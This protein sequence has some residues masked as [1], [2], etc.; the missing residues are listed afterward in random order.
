M[1]P[2]REVASTCACLKMRKAARAVTRD[3]DRALK[4]AGLRITQ[5]SMLVAASIGS[6]VPLGR[7]ADL[8][9]LERTTMTR[10]LQLLERNGLVQVTNTDGRTRS[11]TVTETGIAR[12]A[13]AM[14]LWESA[15]AALREKLGPDGWAAVQKLPGVR[16]GAA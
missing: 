6:G 8:L 15:Q 10:N 1:A 5:F 16:T 13:E 11:V 9:G 2:A 4:P 3:Y 7:L 14:P 12:L